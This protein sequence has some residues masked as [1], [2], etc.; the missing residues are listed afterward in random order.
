METNKLLDTGGLWNDRTNK[1]PDYCLNVIRD[2]P[3][4]AFAGTDL[5]EWEWSNC[6][7][8]VP[9]NGDDDRCNF[10][11]IIPKYGLQQLWLHALVSFDSTAGE[12]YIYRQYEGANNIFS[13]KI[14]SNARIDVYCETGGNTARANSAA[15]MHTV[16]LNVID[17]LVDLSSVT[18]LRLFR[19]GVEATYSTQED[20]TGLSE[21]GNDGDF[22]VGRPVNSLDGGFVYG[23]VSRRLPNL[24][25]II[26][27]CD[28]HFVG[29]G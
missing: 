12:Q 7:W 5:S 13:L 10:G 16:G 4:G 19:N 8:V 3:D 25:T 11:N 17:A 15:N 2:Y 21:I 28:R 23:F 24:R 22:T 14:D 6:V 27:L 9:M 29:I 26:S 20:P 18:G 1:P